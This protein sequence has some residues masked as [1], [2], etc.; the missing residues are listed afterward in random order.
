MPHARPSAACS[1][2]RPR[3]ARVFSTVSRS[4]TPAAY[5]AEYSPRDR[6]AAAQG[7][8]P[9][10]YSRSVTPTAKAAMQGWV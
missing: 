3:K 1:M 2:A 10:A 5:R 4:S 7:L 9:L 6:P 8:M